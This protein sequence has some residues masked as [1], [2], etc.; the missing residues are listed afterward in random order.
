MYTVECDG[1]VLFD[2]TTLLD[3][4][5]LISPKLELNNCAAGSFSAIIPPNNRAYDVCKKITSTIVIKRD[6]EW[7]WE[8]RV[9][10][11][12]IDFYHRKTI[13][14]EGVLAYL[15][16]IVLFAN[17]DGLS[18]IDETKFS[19]K[20]NV[21]DVFNTLLYLYNMRQTNPKRKI[22]PGAI[23]VSDGTPVGSTADRNP[24]EYPNY[25]SV[26]EYI[27]KNFI[28]VYDGYM[29]IRRDGDQLKLD[30]FADPPKSAVQTID[31]GTNLLDFVKDWDYSNICTTIIPRGK[32]L[33][34][35]G[36]NIQKYLLQS[37]RD[38]YMRSANLYSK[39]GN[40]EKVVDFNDCEDANQLRT[41]AA[42]YVGSINFETV[43][44]TV[45]AVDLHWLTNDTPMF[46]M[47][48]SV[49]CFSLPHELDADFPVTAMSIPLDQPENVEYT[50]GTTQS[51]PMSS[52]SAS[53]NSAVNSAINN[54]PSRESVLT[55]AF[56]NS[57]EVLNKRTT[58]YVNIVEQS[59]HSQALVISNTP[60]WTT[61]TKYWQFNMN[62]LGYF[63]RASSTSAAQNKGIA[64]TM[65][66]QINADFI[67]VGTLNADRI[68][69][70]AITSVKLADGSVTNAKVSNNA[71][72]E[73][74]ILSGAVTAVKI[75]DGAIVASKIAA[76]AISAR[77]IQ[78]G[79]ITAD[80]ISAHSITVDRLQYKSITG[81]SNGYIADETITNANIK[82]LSADKI[83]AGTIDAGR[84]T[85]K[86]GDSY[87]DISL[88]NKRITFGGGARID[89]D[90]GRL[91][92]S[93]NTIEINYNDIRWNNDRTFTQRVNMIAADGIN[94][95]G[96][97]G[98]NAGWWPVEFINGICFY[99]G[100]W[101]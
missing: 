46:D 95:D 100:Q 88:A 27:K 14:C 52:S 18:Y 96:T 50:L 5:Q 16:D 38:P 30:Y 57:T 65:D 84:I 24:L 48:D 62:G 101:Y 72:T 33:D 36:T 9:M 34:T 20:G 8:G 75:A 3:D 61:A 55:E 19:T 32:Q 15:N 74:K 6:G 69:A 98:A 41:L 21:S 89:G 28:D 53:I 71:I 44:L 23:T 81:G 99:R 85:I 12:S 78:S 51:S 25:E 66:G 45:K 2:D 35:D 37:I 7:F 54:I 86:S 1:V 29:R 13:R 22:Y 60:T 26:W 58:G 67:T 11:D 10:S 94:A 59:E 91:V 49:H 76:N 4:V 17:L 63:T 83:T 92:L 43:A 73:A 90:G 82:S 47:F 79:A 97:L 87:D 70:G 31:F 56:R 64:I 93:G 39:Y 68:S 80:E 42:N 77:N 40:F